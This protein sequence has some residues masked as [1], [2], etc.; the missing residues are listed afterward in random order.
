MDEN[1]QSKKKKKKKLK[2]RERSVRDCA[3][4]MYKLRRGIIIFQ[5]KKQ[6]KRIQSF[7]LLLS[8]KGIRHKYKRLNWGNFMLIESSL[9]DIRHTELISI[10]VIS[11]YGFGYKYKCTWCYHFCDFSMPCVMRCFQRSV[12]KWKKKINKN[13]KIYINR[14]NVNG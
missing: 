11:W 8:Q 13:K 4:E 9:Q 7:L 10:H 2:G 6:K 3:R 1:C 12:A 14:K 5:Q